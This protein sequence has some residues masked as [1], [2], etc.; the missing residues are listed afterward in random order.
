MGRPMQAA[1]IERTEVK[2]GGGAA[3]FLHDLAYAW[4]LGGEE[5]RKSRVR[6][7]KSE[8]GLES[9][10]C[11]ALTRLYQSSRA[12]QRVHVNGIRRYQYARHNFN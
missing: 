11:E 9:V 3:A 6:P 2:R 1:P 10:D 8:V 12:K 4:L 5:R 7:R